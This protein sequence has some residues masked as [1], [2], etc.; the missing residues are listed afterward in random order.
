MKKIAYLGTALCALSASPVMAKAIPVGDGLTLQPTIDARLRYE[1]VDQDNALK[2]ADA[3]TM[4]IRPGITLATSTGLSILVE[5]E[6]TL[7]LSEIG[8]AHV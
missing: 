6:G 1:T 4:R 2:N 5:G 3:L 7:A 8:R